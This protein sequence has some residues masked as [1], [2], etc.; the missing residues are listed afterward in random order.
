M[1]GVLVTDYFI[2]NYIEKLFQDNFFQ[3][4]HDSGPMK[5]DYNMQENSVFQSKMGIN[6]DDFCQLRRNELTHEDIADA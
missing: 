1:T 2:H 5:L 6:K 4:Q 3:Y